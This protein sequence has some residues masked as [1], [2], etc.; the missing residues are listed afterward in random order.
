MLKNEKDYLS[1][2]L[3]KNAEYSKRVYRNSTNND[4]LMDLNL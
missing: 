4:K 1:K 2:K 3:A